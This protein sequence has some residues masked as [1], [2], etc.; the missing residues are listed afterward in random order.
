MPLSEQHA[1]ILRII[2][3]AK[4]EFRKSLLKYANEE[5][6]TSLCECVLNLLEGNIELTEKQ[7]KKFGKHKKLLRKIAIKPGTWKQK[8]KILQKGGSILIPLLAS[9]LGTVISKFL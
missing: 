7:K 8:K 3:Q 9:V 4:P 2:L 5:L 1:A 6:T